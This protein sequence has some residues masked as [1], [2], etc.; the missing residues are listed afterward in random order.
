MCLDYQKFSLKHLLSDIS[1]IFSSQFE[2]KE[3]LFISEI[4]GDLPLYLNGDY[5]RL[6]QILVNLIG[7]AIKF[8]FYKGSVLLLVKGK[9]IEGNLYNIEFS[10]IDTGIG[11]SRKQI[12]SLFVPFVQADGSIT[13]NFGGTGL[14]LSICKNLVDLMGGNISAKSKEG[15][16]TVFSFDVNLEIP[17][18]SEESLTRLKTIRRQTPIKS[19]NDSTILVVDDNRINLSTTTRFLKKYGHKAL[20]ATSGDE[21]LAII[22]KNQIE[23]ILLDLHMPNM[24]GYEVTRCLREL[25]IPISKVPIIALTADALEGTE[26][27]CFDAG[28]NGYVSKPINHVAL[29]KLIDN[30]TF[31][32]KTE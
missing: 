32:N 20:S 17:N 15:I 19:Q 1:K 22:E 11:I 7:N 2:H 29:I 26:K 30:L 21:A 5:S 25:D 10:V 3:V 12:D 9:C 31:H 23:L 4:V 16:G 8:S 18:F 24:S 14:G 28:F 6:K 13:R 27:A